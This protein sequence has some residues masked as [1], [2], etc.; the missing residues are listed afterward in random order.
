M[1]KGMGLRAS[2]VL[3]KPQLINLSCTVLMTTVVFFQALVSQNQEK[4]QRRFGT[5]WSEGLEHIVK[6]G[7]RCM[8]EGGVCGTQWVTQNAGGEPACGMAEQRVA[9]LGM[10]WVAPALLSTRLASDRLPLLHNPSK[11]FAF[12]ASVPLQM[13]CLSRG[14]PLFVACHVILT[15]SLQWRPLCYLSHRM[16]VVNSVLHAQDY[17]LWWGWAW[18]GL[19]VFTVEMPVSV[20]H[21]PSIQFPREDMY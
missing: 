10:A 8:W 17:F 4:I 3:G 20:R 7:R 11:Q 18:G 13:P 21:I 19:A 6:T 1:R 15:S 5:F 2:N 9:V 14:T 16:C 12:S